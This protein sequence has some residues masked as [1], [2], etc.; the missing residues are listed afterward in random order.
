MAML[1]R[2]TTQCK[3]QQLS[4]L[5]LSLAKQNIICYLALP[6]QRFTSQ[7]WIDNVP[8]HW[9]Q[10]MPSCEPQTVDIAAHRMYEMLPLTA[11]G[12][13]LY[14]LMGNQPTTAPRPP[15]ILP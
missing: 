13:G 11:A 9:Q 5:L 7:L 14:A 8:G 12:Q 2:H 4:S 3:R 10:W 1:G 15:A 6:A